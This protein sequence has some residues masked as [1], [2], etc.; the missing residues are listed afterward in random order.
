MTTWTTEFNATSTD[1][2]DSDH[3]ARS[4]QMITWTNASRQAPKMIQA[5]ARLLYSADPASKA[6]QGEH[7]RRDPDPFSSSELT[8][9]ASRQ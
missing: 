3:E 4:F 5:P 8:R 1:G 2:T 9:V 6:R 7:Q